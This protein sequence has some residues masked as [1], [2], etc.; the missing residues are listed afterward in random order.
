[1]E[2]GESDRRD[3]TGTRRKRRRRRGTGG[4]GQK[5]ADGDK[6]RTTDTTGRAGEERERPG[7]YKEGRGRKR[8]GM[9][10][11]TQGEAER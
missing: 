5:G 10:G 6:K 7:V 11:R 1:M 3:Q 9:S 8:D 4:E 2:H